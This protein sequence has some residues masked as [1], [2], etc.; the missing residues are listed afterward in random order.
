ME[1]M[2]TTTLLILFL[3]VACAIGIYFIYRSIQSLAQKQDELIKD[4]AEVRYRLNEVNVTVE[5]INGVAWTIRDDIENYKFDNDYEDLV[6]ED[7]D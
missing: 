3:L 1:S 5:R 4:V 7:D 2:N 6:D